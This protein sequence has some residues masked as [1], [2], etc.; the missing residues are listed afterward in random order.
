MAGAY[1]DLILE[2]AEGA[3]DT[4]DFSGYNAPVTIDLASGARQ[5]VAS[6]DDGNGGF[7]HLWVTLIGLFTSV[8]GS[9]GDDTLTGNS[10]DNEIYGRGGNDTIRG[11]AGSD[12]LV[13]DGGEAAALREQEQEGPIEGDDT[14]YGEEG[15][16]VLFGNGGDD[17]LSGGAGNDQLFGDDG[18]D[19]DLDAV[20]HIG[21]VEHEDDWDSIER[22]EA[23][24]PPP[25]SG[26][27]GGTPSAGD[28]AAGA[29]PVVGGGLL[30]PV[31]GTDA[32]ALPCGVVT[33]VLPNG[34]SV[35][36]SGLCGNYWAV[37]V[38]DTAETLPSAPQSPYSFV[39]GMTL[40]I[41]Q[42]SDPANLQTLSPLPEGVTIT[43]T[44]AAGGAAG[45]AGLYWDGSAWQPVNLTVTGG[46]AFGV[47]NSSGTII[48]ASQ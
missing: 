9:D 30:I 23:L 47:H 36:I 46:A 18:T 3:V 1:G 45:A 8:F 22:P 28:G 48:L 20:P 2:S 31:T 44:F 24:T 25:A 14:I 35:A 26:G 17:S 13:G 43:W 33:L 29:A 38:A 32:V 40:Q 37:L 19:T 4:L 6:L 11:G 12:W 15:D 42:G 5:L 34:D 27:L 7:N 21:F 16:D 10:L 39:R 41:L